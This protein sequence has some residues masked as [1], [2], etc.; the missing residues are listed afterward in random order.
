MRRQE[1]TA[2]RILEIF[3]SGGMP[4]C[5]ITDAG[6]LGQGEDNQ[7]FYIGRVGQ[8]VDPG[9]MPWELELSIQHRLAPAGMSKSPRN[10][11]HWLKTHNY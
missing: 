3:G 1:P 4:C 10:M 5:G 11:E 7:T 9:T 8:E 6:K 2:I